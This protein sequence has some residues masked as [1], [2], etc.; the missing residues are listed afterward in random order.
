VLEF[1]EEPVKV[2]GTI[3]GCVMEDDGEESDDDPGE[4]PPLPP[5]KVYLIY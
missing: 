3:N 4:M 2:N 5:M 1:E